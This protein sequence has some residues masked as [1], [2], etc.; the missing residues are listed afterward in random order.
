MGTMNTYSVAGAIL[1]LSGDDSTTAL[2]SVKGRLAADNGL[3]GTSTTAADVLA[4]LDSVGI[5]GRHFDGIYL[6][7]DGC[8]WNRSCC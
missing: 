5:P 7:V 1:L 2:S 4:D 3:A 6:V 8:G